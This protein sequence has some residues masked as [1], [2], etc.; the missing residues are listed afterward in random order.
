[1]KLRCLCKV[2]RP[3][4]ADVDLVCETCGQVLGE[5]DKQVPSAGPRGSSRVAYSFLDGKGG[6]KD[7]MPE[8]MRRR[9]RK[10]KPHLE[11]QDLEKF[12]AT[13]GKVGLPTWAQKEAHFIFTK[14]RAHGLSKP[15][16]L[17][18]AIMYVSMRHGMPLLQ[19]DVQD[20][21]RSNLGVQNV[22]DWLAAK[23]AVSKLEASGCSWR[24]PQTDEAAAADPLY[25]LRAHVKR[26][27]R[28][29]PQADADLLAALAGRY[30]G[31]LSAKNCETRAKRAAMQALANMGVL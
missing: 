7:D 23:S 10:G 6:K 4:T 28:R 26:A 31:S 1:M 20:A 22:L 13:V 21:I 29:Y 16:S 15:N 24:M 19:E 5:A 11:S 25:Y 2:P 9:G 17:F 3:V 8:H 18:F 12:S 14:L 30:F 27:L